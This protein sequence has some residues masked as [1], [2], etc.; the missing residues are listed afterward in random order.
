MG[1]RPPAAARSSRWRRSPPL[2]VVRGVA[3]AVDALHDH[4]L[5][6]RDLHPGN[7]IVRPDG[8]PVVID[9]DTVRPDDG[10][11]TTTIA[12]VVGFIAPEVVTGGRGRDADCWSVGMLAVYALLGHPQGSTPTPVLR[13]ELEDRPRRRGRRPADHGRHH[14]DDR[15]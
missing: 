7:V 1:R 4:G 11:A 13:R 14:A 2:A 8:T 3:G 10:A 6:H 5:T 12:G 9:F 15:P